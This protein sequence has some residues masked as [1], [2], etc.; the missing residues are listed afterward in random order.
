MGTGKV[1]L[2]AFL[3]FSNLKRVFGVELSAARF[4]I[5]EKALLNLLMMYPNKYYKHSKRKMITM[6]R[7]TMSTLLILLKQI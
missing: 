3:Q 2:Q 1:A 7:M 6:M 5:A 4:R